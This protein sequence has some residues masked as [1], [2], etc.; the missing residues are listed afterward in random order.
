M[1]ALPLLARLWLHEPD[2]ETVIEAHTRLGMPLA[3]PEELAHAYTDLFVLNVYPYG[4]VF[5][6]EPGELGGPTTE[7]IA[8]MYAKAGFQPRELADV[9]A[10]DHL[11][12]CLAFLDTLRDHESTGGYDWAWI[13]ACCFAVLREPGVHPF[14]ADLAS[15]TIAHSAPLCDDKDACTPAGPFDIRHEGD[16]VTL[17]RIVRFYL[18]PARCGMFLSRGR[19]G[20]IARSLDMRLPFGSR[21]DVARSLFQ[22]TGEGG[23][24]SD[25]LDQLDDEVRAWHAHAELRGNRG[26][27][28]RLEVAATTLSTM[29]KLADQ[30]ASFL[31]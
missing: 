15:V 2:V 1:A 10:P 24:I 9:A 12:L 5:L 21:F 3:D 28:A 18:A 27:L 30:S 6:D 14:Y 16:E 4:S 25:L 23:R 19:L 7:R 29:R 31:E 11:G 26:R 20:H 22:A 13:D 17:G 8:E